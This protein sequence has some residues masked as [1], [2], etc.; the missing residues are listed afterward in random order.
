MRRA[1]PLAVLALVAAL[2]AAGAIARQLLD[3][4]LSLAAVDGLRAWVL[5]FGWLG[6]AIFVGLVSF[7]S[8]L[9]LPS[10]L[11]LVLVG[12]AFGALGGALL[13]GAGL[14]G[15]AL[16]HFAFARAFGDEWVRPRLGEHG[17]LIESHMNRAG[18]WVVA[19]ATGHPAGP[20]TPFNLAAGLSSMPLATFGAAVLLAVP[21]RAGAY[22]VLGSSILE[23]GLLRSL[24]AALVLGALA[25]LPLLHPRVRAWL[26]EGLLR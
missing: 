22:A 25:L 23:W 16:M 12:L 11:V 14:V 19:L 9:F 1:L 26:F 20:M 10:A 3:V 4:E 24:A 6:P 15:S 7:R 21:V 5:G 18:P 8:F 13:G 17:R 2:F